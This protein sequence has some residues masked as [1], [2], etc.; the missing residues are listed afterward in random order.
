MLDIFSPKPSTIGSGEGWYIP[1]SLLTLQTFSFLFSLFSL[2]WVIPHVTRLYHPLSLLWSSTNSTSLL[3]ALNFQL[4]AQ[5]TLFNSILATIFGDFKIHVDDPFNNLVSYFLDSFCFNDL[6]LNSNI[7]ILTPK[8]YFWL[9]Y[10]HKLWYIHIISIPSIPCL[11]STEISTFSLSSATSAFPCPF[12]C[13]WNFL[14]CH[15]LLLYCPLT[16]LPLSPFI[17]C[18]WQT[19]NSS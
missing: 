8:S 7:P 17:A 18:I 14:V 9:L 19:P 4:L 1:C 3:T 13:R 2:P 12:S 6:F 15:S 5:W 10:Y 11:W 16:P